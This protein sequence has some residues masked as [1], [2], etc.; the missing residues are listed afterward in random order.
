MQ[1]IIKIHLEI[2]KAIRNVVGKDYPISVRFG[3]YDYQDGGSRI[4]EIST[5]ARMLEESG[6]K[7]YY[8]KEKQI[9]LLSADRFTK[10][11]ILSE[12]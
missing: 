2:I 9:W 7:N 10:I 11:L 8:K 12:K 3:A 1:D 6:E 5:V 4:E